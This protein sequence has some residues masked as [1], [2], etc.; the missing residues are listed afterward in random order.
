MKAQSKT[1]SRTGVLSDAHIL[2]HCAIYNPIPMKIAN[3]LLHQDMNVN[4]ESPFTVKKLKYHNA[5]SR[6][7]S[8][9]TLANTL[10]RIAGNDT[11]IKEH[12]IKDFLNEIQSLNVNG[13]G[14][15]NGSEYSNGNGSEYSNGTESTASGHDRDLYENLERRATELFAEMAD[16]LPA[17]PSARS[18]SL[19]SM[20]DYRL[21]NLPTSPG[22][23][24]YSRERLAMERMGIFRQERIRLQEEFQ[25][26]PPGA[27]EPYL[28]DYAGPGHLRVPFVTGTGE[29]LGDNPD[30]DSLNL[31]DKFVV[32]QSV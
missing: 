24:R 3:K 4:E 10:T 2:K 28:G 8:F 17:T 13:N 11:F 16:V 22:G 6:P 20:S 12:L 30:R 32:R 18:P 29:I 5:I 19:G 9:N 7:N 25:R 1:M 31:D 26:R 27:Q 14:N 23:T 15:G 21:P